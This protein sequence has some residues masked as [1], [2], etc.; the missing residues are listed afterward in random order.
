MP[1]PPRFTLLLLM[2]IGGGLECGFSHTVRD[3]AD[4][5]VIRAAIKTYKIN[6]GELPTPE[7]GLNS[8]VERPDTLP[9]EKR[10][11]QVMKSIPSDAWGNPYRYLAGEGL[12]DGFGLYS[13]GPDGVSLSAGNDPDDLNTWSDKPSPGLSWDWN[14]K[15]YTFVGSAILAAGAF[16]LGYRVAMKEA[17]RGS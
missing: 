1:M 16:L 5:N 11:A 2:F 4:F 7:A 12:K 6:A 8:L 15:P 14:W 10:W 3:E 13:C 9:S 17:R